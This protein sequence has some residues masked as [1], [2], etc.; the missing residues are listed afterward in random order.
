MYGSVTGLEEK[1]SWSLEAVQYQGLQLERDRCLGHGKSGNACKC[2]S[3]DGKGILAMEKTVNTCHSEENGIL[4]VGSQA[5]IIVL[6][7]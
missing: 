4:A 6:F 1:V 7:K 2:S 5:M 3:F